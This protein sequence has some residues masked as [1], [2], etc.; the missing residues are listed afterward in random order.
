MNKTL[1]L[2]ITVI[3]ISLMACSNDSEST[4]RNADQSSEMIEKGNLFA[5]IHNNGLD[6][7]YR[8]LNENKSITRTVSTNA[9]II[10]LIK[11][12]MNSFINQHQPLSRAAGQEI[13]YSMFETKTI[14]D[15]ENSMS[16][17]ERLYVKNAISGNVTSEDILKEVSNDTTLSIERRQAI[18]CFITTYKASSEYWNTHYEEW[19]DLTSKNEVPVSKSIHF[20]WKDVAIADAYWGYTGMLS[21]GLNPWVGGGAAAVGSAFACLK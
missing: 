10:Q 16:P 8:K 17:K 12:A 13:D 5:T 7:I 18:I 2:L 11:D 19:E 20:N 3:T 15:I 4:S 6:A 21:S 9:S 1:L 14:D